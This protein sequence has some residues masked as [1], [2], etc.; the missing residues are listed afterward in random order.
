MFN[1]I[2]RPMW[3]ILVRSF[4]GSPGLRKKAGAAGVCL[5]ASIVFA[6][7]TAWISQPVYKYMVGEDHV[8]WMISAMIATAMFFFSSIVGYYLAEKF[9]KQPPLLNPAFVGVIALLWIC[10]GPFD[11]YLGATS[12]AQ[13]RA[14]EKHNIQSFSQSLEGKPLPYSGEISELTKQQQALQDDKVSWKG[15]VS[16]R[17]RS[18]RQAVKLS[19][20]IQKYL[21][22]QRKEVAVM[23]SLHQKSMAMATQKQ[24]QTQRTMSFVSIV[25]YLLQIVL[26]IPLCLF[27]IA[28]DTEDGVRDGNYNTT[29][30]PN[31]SNSVN[32]KY[33]NDMAKP[34]LSPDRGWGSNQPGQGGSKGGQ[35]GY[36]TNRANLT[37]G[38]KTGVKRGVNPGVN[39]GQTG[40]KPQPTILPRGVKADPGD[41][42]FLNKYKHVVALVLAGESTNNVVSKSSVSKSTVK[43]VKRIMRAVKLIPPYKK[44]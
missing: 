2:L 24:A 19:R 42:E 38:V 18:S 29:N 9:S 4:S 3:A 34:P 41:I 20:D 16:T 28:C 13:E 6:Y 25:L 22:M 26:S 5:I 11:A 21:D 36:P 8:A 12:G 35:I 44:R 15:V 33:N 43:N 30:S 1:H 27:D 10:L 39:P 14:I 40:V 37:R 32:S 31:I 23:D 17:E 7:F